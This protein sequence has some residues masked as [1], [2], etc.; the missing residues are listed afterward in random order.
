MRRWLAQLLHPR[1]STPCP[2]CLGDGYCWDLHDL[3]EK[4]APVV[5]HEPE[6][7]DRVDGTFPQGGA[8]A[9]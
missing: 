5:R 8:G 6:P 1:G 4:S 2:F 3:A 9:A 7:M